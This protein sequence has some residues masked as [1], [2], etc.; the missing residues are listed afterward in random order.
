[1][2]IKSVN[3]PIDNLGETAID[4][5]ISIY[6]FFVFSKKLNI[7]SKHLKVFRLFRR[8]TYY[9]SKSSSAI[10]SVHEADIDY[11]MQKEI[12]YSEWEIIKEKFFL[13][14]DETTS[15]YCS[16]EWLNK[17]NKQDS[18]V[19]PRGADLC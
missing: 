12:H 5:I 2:C 16:I 6:E 11:V 17:T 4:I 10:E 14:R 18:S 19:L 1:M 15:G 3:A 13:L 7:V 9:R 8:T